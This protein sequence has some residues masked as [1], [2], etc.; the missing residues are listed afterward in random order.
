MPSLREIRRKRVVQFFSRIQGIRQDWKSFTV[1]HFVAEGMSR[2]SVYHIIN[3]YVARGTVERRA[4]SGR[5]SVKM[6]T[7]NRQRLKRMVNHRTGVSQRALGNLFFCSQQYISRMIKKLK[8]SYRKRVKVPKYK[9]YAAM[10]EAKKR[11]RK[12]YNKFR[13]VDFVIDDE[14]YF[15]LS[16][17]QMTGNRGYYTSDPKLTPEK[18][19]TFGKKKFEPKVML[20]IAMSP[21]G[22]SRPVLTSGRSM[23]VTAHSYV[24]NCLNPHL[25][26]FLNTHYPHGQGYVFWPDK[27]SAHY[28][29]LTTTFLS[30]NNI[31]YVKKEDN[32][33]EVPQC[34][35]VEDF[36]GLLATRVYHKNWVAKDAEHLKRRI[37]K[38]LREI[39]LSTVQATMA[40]VRRRL[41]RAYRVGLLSVCH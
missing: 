11:C 32:P 7:A 21:K 1:A 10:R 9:D 12:L 17:Y 3:N 37:R 6:N 26:R 35:P 20:W 22:I 16:G 23:S 4:G 19:R 28:A 13:T 27:A 38:C 15:G 8:I 29:G 18:V 5:P 30:D 40:S 33:T 39:P 41:L 25:L 2:S 14:K 24:N 34:R 31:E 36:F